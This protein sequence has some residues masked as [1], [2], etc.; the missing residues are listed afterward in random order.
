[1][2]SSFSIQQYLQLL[3][4]QD[5]KDISRITEMPPNQDSDVWQYEQLRYFIFIT[6]V[7]DE[8]Q[9]IPKSCV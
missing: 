8:I 2:E 3:I 6:T 4:R 1:M 7:V 5:A 9:L